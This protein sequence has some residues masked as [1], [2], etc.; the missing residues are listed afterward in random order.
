MTTIQDVLWSN[1]ET[2]V[3]HFF[4]WIKNVCEIDENSVTYQELR[5]IIHSVN[6]ISDF[7]NFF[8]GDID[9]IANAVSGLVRYKEFSRIA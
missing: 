9:N 6:D 5:E 3:H 1:W 7:A 8:D 2:S 4:L